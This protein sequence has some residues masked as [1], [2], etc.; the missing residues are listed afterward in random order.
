M[1]A[2]GASRVRSTLLVSS[3]LLLF[4]ALVIYRSLHV[5]GYQCTVCI[6]FR[7]QSACRKGE[8][9]TEQEAR[10]GAT[11]NACAFVASGVT[12]SIACE[13]SQPT[14]VECAAID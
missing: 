11:N 6:D 8:G 14:K 4:M 12:D 7:G 1:K 2:T 13:R 9:P 3:G 10:T 5:A